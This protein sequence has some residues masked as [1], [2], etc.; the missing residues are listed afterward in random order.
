MYGRFPIMGRN[1]G[2]GLLVLALAGGCAE[3]GPVEPPE[4]IEPERVAASITV[5]PTSATLWRAGAT[6]QLTA[7]VLDQNGEAMAGAAMSWS[8]G[9]ASVASVSPSGMVTAVTEGSAEITAEVHGSSL[10]ASA[11]VV[12]DA[13]SERDALVAFYHATGG[14]N[15]NRRENWLT[16]KPMGTWHGITTDHQGG[17]TRIEFPQNNRMAGSL[18]PELGSLANLEVLYIR[19]QA[20][21]TGPIP[22]E[23]GSLANLEVLVLD[24][25]L[26]GSIPPALR[27]LS[28]L[29]H[30]DLE[31]NQ[32]TGRIPAE[33]A[34]LASLKVLDLSTNALTGPV[35]REFGNF[36]SLE[37]LVLRGRGLTGPIPPELG[38]VES[39]K[40]LDLV[41]DFTGSIP[42]EL[43]NLA[44][45][46]SLWLGRELTG[47]IPPELGQLSNLEKLV[48]DGR[49]SGTLP[50]EIGNLAELE[51]L[52]VYGSVTGPIPPELGR[53]NNLLSLR[54]DAKFTGSIPPE[55]GN[56]ANLRS[57]LIA[58]SG[59][60]LTGPIPPELGNLKEL[61]NLFLASNGLT[62]AIPPELGNLA[63]LRGLSLGGNELSGEIPP[64]LANL[65]S[66]WGLDLGNNQLT[67]PIPPELGGLGTLRSLNLA[68]NEL[69][70]EIPPELGN[71]ASLE[72]LSLSD[73]ELT[74]E[75]PPELGKLA[76]LEGL[77]VDD[78]E[79]LTGPIP[80]EFVNLPLE[81]FRWYRTGLCAP[82]DPAFVEW[83]GTINLNMPTIGDLDTR[84]YKCVRD[85]LVAL[86]EATGGPDWNNSTNWLTKEP[87]SSWHGVTADDSGSPTA[88]FLYGNGL[89]GTLPSELGSLTDL[90]RL[91]LR[92]NELSDTIPAALGGLAR[93]RELDLAHNHLSGRLP[94]ELG[95]LSELAVLQIEHNEF[96]GGLPGSLSRL[97]KLE[98]FQWNE[99]GLCAPDLAW[100]REWLA[101]VPKQVGGDGCESSPVLLS[102]AAVH[103][104]QAA[105]SMDGDVPLVAG[106]EALLRVFPVAD[107][108]NAHRPEARATFYLDGRETYGTDMRLGSRFGIPEE[109]DPGRLEWSFEAAVPSGVLVPGVELVV[110]IDPG[111]EA[112]EGSELRVPAAGRMPLDVREMPVMELT[113]IPVLQKSN[114]DSSV[115]QWTRAIAAQ[116]TSHPAVRLM[117]NVLPVADLDM[118]VRDEALVTD[119][120]L[121]APIS[122]GSGLL[123]ALA[124]A[125]LLEGR[126][127][128]YHGAVAERRP[129]EG[130]VGGVAR[131]ERHRVSVAR[132]TAILFAHELGHNMGL[133]HPSCGPPPRDA[134]YPYPRGQT[135]VW[136]YSRASGSL[137]PPS[138]GDIMGGWCTSPPWISDYH[139]KKALEVRL[140]VENAPVLAADAT[141]ARR[142]LLWGSVGAQGQLRLDPAFVLDAPAKLPEADGP[143]RLEGIGTGGARAFSLE[144]AIEAIHHG[145]G[146]GFL[147][148]IPFDEGWRGVLERIVLSGPA[149]TATLDG[150]TRTP[151]TL[152]LDP[153]TRHLR[154]VL[155]GEGA[156]MGVGASAMDSESD[157]RTRIQVSYG[158]PW[159]VPGRTARA[160]R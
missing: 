150:D 152:V 127:G 81:T 76:S 21:L 41:N 113:I 57:L 36:A 27:G 155:R 131:S 156:G 2:L 98:D 117:T 50:V 138:A 133:K 78:N 108:A 69:S 9:N 116:G 68:G 39:L 93:L 126:T 110:E 119:Y 154:A 43:G 56:L 115:F 74:G 95:N 14:P 71:L 105:Q 30:L 48:L 120:D 60:Q 26:T 160:S 112:A 37:V 47:S 45:L 55:L 22:P 25:S 18:P 148:M 123:N 24:G 33:L 91:D 107:R 10:S 58:R 147:F 96:S 142:L 90:E 80:L 12:V 106:R 51:S 17:V 140:K 141:R 130:G 13:I 143:Y 79:G 75:I 103:L 20:P 64:E 109:V 29:A 53:L 28:K 59:T 65:A 139:F 118:T 111:G 19:G 94:V 136:G 5:S 49:F 4:P 158:L 144:F 70:G 125:R 102:V 88:L 73:N 122:P 61:E 121:D 16:D 62:G 77:N 40:V 82:L 7:T 8:S 92:R 97:A 87:V 72:G 99:S 135:G 1:C 132:P 85:A 134:D 32:L 100:F 66:L 157:A 151:M 114:P 23:L 38:N 104:N 34:E 153:D 101:S 3:E 6:L 83:M 67:G 44:G 124:L 54:L 11:A 129:G 31:R 84:E 89:R 145:H 52:S 137:V 128:Y 35:P 42:P 63:T 86:Y 15:W 46:D 149:G 159:V 146:G